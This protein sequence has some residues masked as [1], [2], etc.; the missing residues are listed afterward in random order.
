MAY[1]FRALDEALAFITDFDQKRTSQLFLPD[2]IR[3]AIGFSY[4]NIA[5]ASACKW[6]QL[7][8]FVRQTLIENLLE[9]LWE[10]HV[11]C[12]LDCETKAS[13]YFH[14]KLVSQGQLDINKGTSTRRVDMPLVLKRSWPCEPSFW[15]NRAGYRAS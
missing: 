9:L 14:C 4:N 13:Y 8:D 5:L 3:I 6:R 15:G 10:P 7:C 11:F 1:G 2:T 12:G